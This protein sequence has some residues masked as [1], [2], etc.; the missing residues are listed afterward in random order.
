MLATDTEHL[1]Q[2]TTHPAP[3]FHPDLVLRFL[4]AVRPHHHLVSISARAGG[5]R[6]LA[7]DLNGPDLEADLLAMGSRNANGQSIYFH[8]NPLPQGFSGVKAAKTDVLCG[9]FLQV[10]VD[11]RGAG[12]YDER[13]ARVMELAEALMRGECPPTFTI[14]SGNGVNVLWRL[15]APIW[16]VDDYERVNREINAALGASGTLNIDRILKVPGTIAWSNKVKIE[17]KGYPE[18]AQAELLGEDPRAWT[19]EEV[20]L[21]ARAAAASVGLSDFGDAPSITRRTAT[22]RGSSPRRPFPP[23]IAAGEAEELLSRLAEV[24]GSAE[25][26]GDDWPDRS[27]ALLRLA[28]V[29]RQ[30]ELTEEEFEKVVAAADESAA[31]GHVR[32]QEDPGRALARAWEASRPVSAAEDFGGQPAEEVDAVQE[33][34][35][36]PFP[37]VG[38]AAIRRDADGLPILPPGDVALGVGLSRVRGLVGNLG[39]H[40]ALAAIRETAV[41]GFVGAVA[42]VSAVMGWRYRAMFRD[43]PAHGNI[44]ATLIGASGIGKDD[45]VRLAAEAVAGRGVMQRSYASD[46]ALHTALAST[47]PSQPQLRIVDELGR[48]RQKQNAGGGDAHALG[49]ETILNTLYA[50]AQGRLEGRFYSDAKAA[51]PEVLN[52]YVVNVGLTTLS[53]F[54]SSV[55][56]SNIA[57]GY[58][59]RIIPFFAGSAPKR[60]LDAEREHFGQ[61]DPEI[62]AQLRWIAQT[63]DRAAM[64]EEFAAQTQPITLDVRVSAEALAV[65]AEFGRFVEEKRMAGGKTGGLWLRADENARRLALVLAVGE[66]AEASLKPSPFD[67]DWL[68]IFGWTMQVA[69]DIVQAG[70]EEFARLVADEVHGSD[71]EEARARILQAVRRHRGNDGWSRHRDVM[72]TTQN[73]RFETQRIERELRGLLDS[74]V[75]IKKETAPTAKG[76]ARGVCYRL[77]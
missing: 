23:Q 64:K 39:R 67:N 34:E 36:D 24:P 42:A 2:V 68:V 8:A 7:L 57:D 46:Q 32:D 20:L 44:Y 55:S 58:L 37:P 66:A 6:R 3:G 22:S 16:D 1:Q 62:T 69:V 54:M 12:T 28:H 14:G 59:N 9:E 71:A 61:W 15:R 31:H 74:G 4:Q 70:M 50:R 76:G 38:E 11:P 75:V 18:T 13:K 41:P 30:A 56:P 35:A 27:R 77:V 48:A 43:R 63:R 17:E 25:A 26:L 60:A 21:A 40:G 29:C 73:T 52:P 72:K 51:K 45:V 53:A 47:T 65:D 5:A 33:A 49:L 10:D 19:P